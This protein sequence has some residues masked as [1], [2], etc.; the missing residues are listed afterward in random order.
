M[1]KE[2]TKAFCLG[3][4]NSII[5]LMENAKDHAARTYFSA[6]AEG[7]LDG[8]FF[9]DIINDEEYTS[10]GEKI[11]TIYLKDGEG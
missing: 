8:L 3:R 2:S 5:S 1:S 9:G 4:L 7:F 11:V 6:Q 10:I